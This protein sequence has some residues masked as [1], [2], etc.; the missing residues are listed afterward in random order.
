[1]FGELFE[2]L[3]QAIHNN[4]DLQSF[5]GNKNPRKF[6]PSVCSSLLKFDKAV[7]VNFGLS[8]ATLQRFKTVMLCVYEG[9]LLIIA[10][11]FQAVHGSVT[12]VPVLTYCVNENL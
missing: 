11:V 6:L 7:E 10:D 4:G 3:D 9:H 2:K 8:Q 1:M 12:F 5:P